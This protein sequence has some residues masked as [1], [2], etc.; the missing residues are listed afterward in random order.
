MHSGMV[1]PGAHAV[2]APGSS[3]LE[4]VLLSFVEQVRLCAPQ[5]YDFGAAV[6]LPPRTPLSVINSI[7]FFIDRIK[8]H[9]PTCNQC[10]TI[11][12]DLVELIRKLSD[13]HRVRL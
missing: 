4:A 5:V 10:S 7:G 13:R 9:F 6:P 3:L 11:L 8:I 12:E 2:R 1:S